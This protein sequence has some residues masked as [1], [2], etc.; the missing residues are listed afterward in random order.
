MF[1]LTIYFNCFWEH[2]LKSRTSVE[3]C[4]TKHYKKRHISYISHCYVYLVIIYSYNSFTTFTPFP[5]S[6]QLLSIKLINIQ[7]L[8]KLFTLRYHYFPINR[9]LIRFYISLSQHQILV[10]AWKYYHV[11]RNFMYLNL[12]NYY[13][14]PIIL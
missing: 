12:I 2:N 11:I 1:T 4:S 9:F 6:K 14:K 7:W 8:Q 10:V 3:N 5:Q 13:V